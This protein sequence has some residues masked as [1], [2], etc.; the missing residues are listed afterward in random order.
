MAGRWPGKGR[1]PIIN[2]MIWQ[3]LAACRGTDLSLWFAPDS[4]SKDAR[5]ER[6]RVEDA[7]RI[8]V[9]CPVS[10][11]CLDYSV[12]LGCEHGIWGG[13]TELERR[14]LGGCADAA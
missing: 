7:K 1:V 12:R 10:V 3:D 9:S 8:C 11:Q 14:G 13:L 5:A 4:R 6:R 2:D